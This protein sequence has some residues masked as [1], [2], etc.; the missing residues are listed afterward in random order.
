MKLLRLL[1]VLCLF[2]LSDCLAQDSVTAVGSDRFKINGGRTF[3]MGSN[4]RKEWKTPIRVP[5]INL[6]TEKGGITVVKLG[7]GKQTKSLRVKDASGKEYN[8][9]SIQKFITNET[10]PADLQSEAA[11]DLVA[12]GV[13]ASYPYS[14]LSMQPLAE[15]A[16]VPFLK[17]RL[18]M[19]PDDARLGEHQKDF[20]NLL[21]Y[22]EERLPENVD[23]GYDTEE[24]VEKLKDDND[25]NVD[26]LALLR[27]RILD[28]FVMDL[29]RHEGQWEWGAVDKDKG[30]TYFPIPKDRDQ[31]FYINRGVLPGIIKW[32][33]LVPQL[34]GFAQKARNIN[35]FNFAA[36]NLDRFFL[37]GL[38]EQDWQKAVDE[39]VPKMTDEVIENAIRQ[40][41]PE[42]YAISGPSIVHTLKNR[43]NYI[44][45]DVMQYYRF[46]AENVDVVTSD[47]KELFDITLNDDGSV[48]LL[49]YKITN[50]GEQST[51]MFDRVFN[52]AHTKELRLYGMGGEDKFILKGKND[53]IKIRMIGGD[54]VDVFNNTT[55]TGETGIVYDSRSENNE[56]TGQL[57]NRMRNDTMAN[58]YERLGYEYNKVIPFLSVNYN[59]DDGLFLGVSIKVI[60]H[61]FRKQPYKNLHEFTVNHSLSTSAWNFRYYAEFIS[62][63]SKNSDL[64]FDADIKAPNNTTNFFGFG[65]LSIY[66][67]NSPGEFRFYRARYQLGDLS[68][69]LRHNFSKKVFMTLGPTYEFFSLDS[70]DS[71]NRVRN[72]VLNTVASGLDPNKVFKKQSYFG[73]KFSLIADIRD[74]RIIPQK[75]IYW[76]NTIRYLSGANDDSYENVTQFNSELTFYV[77]LIKN[78]LTFANR[79]GGGH[80][81]GDFEFIHAQYIGSEDN[82]RGYRKYRFAGKTKF[83]NNAELRLRVANF[84]TYLFPGSLGIHAFYDAGRIWADQNNDNKWLSGYGGGFWISPLRRLVL[85]FT[86][87][88]SKE[89]KLPLI[90]LGWKF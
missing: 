20:G 16:G 57:K 50:E 42:V 65:N 3:W 29:D 68:L 61:G 77:P 66:N 78:R 58:Y 32:P 46:L 30:K 36:R 83:F 86:Y 1:I 49:V 73:G 51:K 47:K 13:S 70:A 28:M 74:N 27:A 15:A 71:K 80:T 60:S 8:F 52:P 38:N 79:I 24:V 33:W 69:L 26:Q 82:L 54:G 89:D 18:V 11:E 75:G 67:K 6:A 85:S 72:I 37:N 48:H 53:K 14:A 4:Y 17:S 19:I 81:A 25:N 10:L 88:A 64:L 62:V 59:R 76:L 55:S 41:P 9:R 39:F 23:K 43:R 44:V 21:A 56:L 87:A 31:A 40:Q 22:F 2:P 45:G 34:Q 12:D 84:K 63:F 5:V 7:G 35:R 90:G